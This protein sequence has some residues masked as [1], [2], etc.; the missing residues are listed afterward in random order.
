MKRRELIASEYSPVTSHPPIAIYSQ[1]G[2]QVD[3]L[4]GQLAIFTNAPTELHF[5]VPNNA[6]RI[7]AVVGMNEQSHLGASPTDGIEVVIFERK[8]D[9]SRR[10]IY[11]R[12]LDPLNQPDDRGEQ[13][14]TIDHIGSATGP[15]VFALY[16]GPSGNMACDWGYWRYIKFK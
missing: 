7:N 14:I 10:V 5:A 2:V 9:G 15:L 16:A 8:L 6:T 12:Y 13:L 1:W 11:Q 4:A 3:A